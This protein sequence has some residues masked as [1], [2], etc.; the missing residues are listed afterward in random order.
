MGFLDRFKSQ[1]DI[2]KE[3][4]KEVPWVQLERMEQIEELIEISKAVPVLIFKHSTSCGISRMVL[5]EFET[6]YDIEEKQLEPFFLDLKR[7]RD[8]SQAIAN[9]FEV[10]HESPQVLLIKNGNSVYNSSH[11]AISLEAIKKKI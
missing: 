10:T 8:I 3:E 2:V 5:K 9:Q 1:R 4:I 6:D 7:Y 11:G